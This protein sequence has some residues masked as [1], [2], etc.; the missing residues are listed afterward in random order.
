LGSAARRDRRGDQRR[1]LRGAEPQRR[2]GDGELGGDPARLLGRAP[3][4]E[5]DAVPLNEGEQPLV[6]RVGVARGVGEKLV[7][8]RNARLHG[9][10]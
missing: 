7:R 4:G 5:P 2:A 3:G 10:E 6:D 1:H 9:D 8:V